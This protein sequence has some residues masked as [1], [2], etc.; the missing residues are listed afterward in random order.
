[1]H[2]C[3][4][5]RVCA[6]CMERACSQ[7]CKG[8]VRGVHTSVGA[9]MSEWCVCMVCGDRHRGVGNE[10][11]GDPDVSLF[12]NKR[13]Q[14]ASGSRP[15]A[16]AL[17]SA[18]RPCPRPR[19]PAC[20][21][22]WAL[23]SQCLQAARPPARRCSWSRRPVD[24]LLRTGEDRTEGPFSRSPRASLLG[25]GAEALSSGGSARLGV[26]DDAPLTP[27]PAPP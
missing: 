23:L 10:G 22:G 6:V 25:P 5:V 18:P 7:P 3:V 15:P 20:S 11:G 24:C 13:P 9:Y 2:T 27:S 17:P 21:W 1:M 4:C 14:L 16:G 19:G 12:V 26:Q 8:F